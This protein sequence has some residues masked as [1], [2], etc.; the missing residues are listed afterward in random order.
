[1]FTDRY[2]TSKLTLEE[3]D[4]VFG[5]QLVEHVLQ[6]DTKTKA[7]HVENPRGTEETV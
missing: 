5:D 2:R 6:G 4:V 3:M 1:M 7:A